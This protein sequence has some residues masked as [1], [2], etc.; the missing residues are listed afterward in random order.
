MHKRCVQKKKW[1][2]RVR[3]NN[4]NVVFI[5]VCWMN[6]ICSGWKLVFHFKYTLFGIT[7]TW[8]SFLLIF[9]VAFVWRIDSMDF[10]LKRS[11]VEYRKCC[12]HFFICVLEH[13]KQII[14][15][16]MSIVVGL[17]VLLPISR[18]ANTQQQKS[19]QLNWIFG[20]QCQN[21]E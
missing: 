11:L 4:R 15:T 12:L 9:T 13:L 19:E 3:E 8:F 5:C 20:N 18:R 14:W 17:H 21:Y 16:K 1:N 10:E 2:S 7:M 6:K